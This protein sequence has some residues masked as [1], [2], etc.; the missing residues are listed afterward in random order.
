MVNSCRQITFDEIR[1][2]FKVATETKKTT[3]KA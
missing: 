2:A 3:K 1:Q